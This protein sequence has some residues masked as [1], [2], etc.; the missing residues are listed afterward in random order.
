MASDYRLAAA[1]STPSS[2]QQ[3]IDS[4]LHGGDVDSFSRVNDPEAGFDPFQGFWCQR[5]HRLGDL[6]HLIPIAIAMQGHIAASRQGPFGA[7]AQIALQ[8]LHRKI[9]GKQKSLESDGAA[10]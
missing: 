3:R 6:P 9:V 4:R 2:G 5:R 10:D 1:L 7:L 8:R